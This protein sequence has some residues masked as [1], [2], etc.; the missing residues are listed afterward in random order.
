MKQRECHVF[1]N[2]RTNE[3]LYYPTAFCSK[4][5][6]YGDVIEYDVEHIE[7][8]KYDGVQMVETFWTPSAEASNVNKLWIT[9][10][11][12]ICSHFCDASFTETH[13]SIRTEQTESKNINVNFLWTKYEQNPKIVHK[14]F[15]ISPARQGSGRAVFWKCE[16]FVNFLKANCK[17]FMNKLFPKIMNKM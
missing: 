17:F 12:T 9:H 2:N 4:N 1:V 11:F 13:P 10:L 16:R 7:D 6:A 3:K 14:K 5:R 8:W 15:T